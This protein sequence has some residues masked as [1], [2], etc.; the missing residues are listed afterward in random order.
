MSMQRSVDTQNLLLELMVKG[1]LSRADV[2]RLLHV[3][4]HTVASYLKPSTTKSG[5]PPPLALVE[6]LAF[7][8][9]LTG[10]IPTLAADAASEP[11]TAAAA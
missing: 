9:G 1:R 7:K 11:D 4:K 3:S 8:T 10:L 6:L 5:T 2:A